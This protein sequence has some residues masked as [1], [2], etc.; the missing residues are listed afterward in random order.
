MLCC[1]CCS[2][3]NSC[4]NIEFPVTRTGLKKIGGEECPRE[5]YR[6][7]VALFRPKSFPTRGAGSST[8]DFSLSNNVRIPSLFFVLFLF[9]PSSLLSSPLFS[10]F[11]SSSR[12][13][14]P[15]SY[16]RLS[17]RLPTM[18]G[19]WL[20]LLFIEKTGPLSSLVFYNTLRDIHVVSRLRDSQSGWTL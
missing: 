13:S 4:P 16:R 7:A 18:C 3:I 12:S 11:L 19:S 2:H 8:R 6:T 15:E 20:V 17:F 14:D 9:R 1:C 10:L 5:K